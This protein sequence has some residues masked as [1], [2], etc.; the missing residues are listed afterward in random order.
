VVSGWWDRWP[1][2]LIGM[3]TGEH[4]CV[5]DLDCKK[6]KNGLA[7]VSDW[8]ERSPLIAITGSDG[9]HL[10]FLPDD[11]I[12][13]TTDEI[14]LGVD[15]RGK[16]G[17]VIVPPSQGYQWENGRDL[18][19]LS[20]LPPWPDDLRPSGA[21]RKE[22]PDK[23]AMEL[24]ADDLDKLAYAVGVIPN[25]LPGYKEWKNFGMAIFAATGGNDF[26][27]SLFDGFSK[28]W[29]SKSGKYDAANVQKAWQQI[30]GSLPTKIGAKWIYRK[31]DKAAP[32]WRASYEEMRAAAGTAEERAK[33]E[34]EKAKAKAREEELLDALVKAE[35]LD[36]ERQRNEAKEELGVSARAIDNEKPGA[37]MPQRR[38]S[39]G[40]GLL[41]RGRNRPTATRC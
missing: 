27:F 9:R 2:A 18:T 4:F 7:V 41:S 34:E 16:G 31:A 35:G 6:G 5:L 25:D 12:G 17:Y 10:Y 13:C 38:R 36:Y 30:G 39:T 22:A 14:A 28:K 8:S 24:L 37:K 1:T 21:A 3:P 11:E 15:T 20:I 23:P 32:G 33:V 40:I 29:T 19:D 26:G